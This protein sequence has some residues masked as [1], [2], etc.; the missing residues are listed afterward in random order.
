[1]VE[2]F[3]F[4]I[5]QKYSY[6]LTGLITEIAVISDANAMINGMTFTLLPLFL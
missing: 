3:S 5:N 1:M 6:K 4:Y 2:A